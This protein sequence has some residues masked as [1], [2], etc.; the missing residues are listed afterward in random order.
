MRQLPRSHPLF[1]KELGVEFSNPPPLLG[2]SNGVR[3][4][5]IHSTTDIGATWQTRK[6][7]TKDHFELAAALYLYATGMGS[8][9]SKLQ[10]LVVETSTDQPAH[11]IDVARLDYAGNADP[12]PGAWPRLA[13]LARAHFKTDVRLA[14]VKFSDLD[15]K[16]QQL[17]VLTGTARTTFTQ[18]DAAALKSYLDHG[19]TLF[20][21]AAGGSPEFA[22]S[23]QQLLKEIYPDAPLAPLPPDHPLYVGAFDGGEK[24]TD[25]QFQKFGNLKLGRTLSTPAL[26]AI[27]INNR[28][29]VIF[30]EY[31]ISSG[32]LG[33]G[34]WGIV[35]YAPASSEALARNLLLY[36]ARK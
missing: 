1:S 32:F 21:E 14:T 22:A 10:P 9:R 16:K 18:S 35:G 36:V 25:I 17:A 12:E 3:E 4:L 34:T 7:A 19:G 13:R 33:T 29:P 2:M 8:L 27:T 30:S 20:A 26:Q 28:T 11:T 6:F 15:P 5:W 23:L 31:D 24:I